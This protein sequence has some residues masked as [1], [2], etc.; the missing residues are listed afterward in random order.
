MALASRDGGD[1]Q[2]DEM[3]C[4]LGVCACER[5]KERQRVVV[6]S[7]HNVLGLC[8]TFFVM[9]PTTFVMQRTTFAML[10]CGVG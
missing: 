7:R 10:A 6:L 8:T 4:V 1:S 3:T 2:R 5:E 9:Q